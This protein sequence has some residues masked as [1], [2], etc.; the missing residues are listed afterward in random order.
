[1]FEIFNMRDNTK[2]YDTIKVEKETMDASR[3]E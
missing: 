3:E 1:V 2:V